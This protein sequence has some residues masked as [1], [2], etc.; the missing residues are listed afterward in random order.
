M[1]DRM[2]GGGGLGL[3]PQARLPAS[4]QPVAGQ[5][6]WTGRAI[7]VGELLGCYSLPGSLTTAPR[8]LG[9]QACGLEPDNVTAMLPW[10]SGGALHHADR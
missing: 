8:A 2:G 9:N 10:R 1:E 7:P 3:S 6:P 5:Y 4:T